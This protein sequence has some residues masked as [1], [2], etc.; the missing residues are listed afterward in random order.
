MI[1]EKIKKKNEDTFKSIKLV[2]KRLRSAS[3]ILERNCNEDVIPILF[4]AVNISVQILLAL[5]Q[6]H[7]QDFLKDVKFLEKE[8]QDE[9][10]LDGKTAEMFR[11]LYEKKNKYMSEMDFYQDERS[12]KDTFKKLEKFV[13]EMK[14]FLRDQ[15]LTPRGRKI[16]KQIKKNSVFGGIFIGV[17]IV[18]FFLVN[19][20]VKI[21]GPEHGLFASYYNN[22]N[23][24]GHAVIERVDGRIDFN[25][26]T[27]KPHPELDNI[28]SVKWNGQIKINKS[29][30]YTFTVRSDEGTRLVLDGKT[31]INTWSDSD[32]SVENSGD[33]YLEEGFY[34]IK[35]EY[36]FDQKLADIK[37][38]WSPNSFRKRKI[39][40]KYL[41]PSLSLDA[42]N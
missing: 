11:F 40:N 42:L 19:L 13:V 27:K 6:K 1:K 33:I 9:K 3:F 22:K 12:L 41:Y 2:E 17:F 34:K 26:S 24:K 32:R 8:Y 4:K 15:M 39:K 21:L 18:I 28:F 37:L 23:L 20:G 31:I 5:K 35:L 29:D 14:R 10:L 16:K 25:W 36:F 30:S 7:S 38:L